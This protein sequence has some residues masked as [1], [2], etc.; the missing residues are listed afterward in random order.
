MLGLDAC[1][2]QIRDTAEFNSALLAE[3]VAWIFNLPYRRVALSSYA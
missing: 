1:G 2:L 3:T